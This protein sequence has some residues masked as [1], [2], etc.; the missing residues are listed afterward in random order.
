MTRTLTVTPFDPVSA[1][2]A[3]RLR[4]GQ[5]LTDSHS[6]AFPEDPPLVPE[7]EALGLT[8][9]TPGEAMAHFVVWDGEEGTEALGWGS[10]DYSLTENLHAVHARLV[11]HPSKRRR[12]L[13][14]DLARVL[15]GV[16]RREGRRVVTFGTNDREPAGS[17]LARLLG[18]EPALPMR[19]SQLDLAR[20][21]GDL[22]AAWTTRPDGDPYRLHLWERVPEEFLART[23]EIMMVMNT[24]PRGD[25]D[26]ED[27]QIRPEMIR[28]W[29]AMGD[30]SGTVRL[31]LAAE[32]TRTGELAGYTE[33]YWNPGR[34]PLAHQGATAVRPSQRGQGLGKWLK[35]EMLSHVR[36][37]CPGVQVI[38]TGNAHENAAML[39]INVAMGFEPWGEFTEWQVRLGEK[40]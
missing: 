3:A 12:G 30:E 39:G 17:I 27:W 35:A 11:V 20:V 10:L 15:E 7:R 2:A 14:R 6:F 24:A 40:G 34:A 32:D 16:A 9:L 31:L 8:H 13:G 38:R 36:E 28:A 1:S 22:L 23:A 4:V 19:V 25:L 33:I 37:R 29:E 5:L 21:S 18:A 26:V